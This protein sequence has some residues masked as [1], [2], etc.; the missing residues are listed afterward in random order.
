MVTSSEP[1][2]KVVV[3]RGNSTITTANVIT[4]DTVTITSGDETKTYT[5]ILYGDINKDGKISILDLLAEQKHL[6][7]TNKLTGTPS[8]AADVN[9]D[10]KISILD[11]LAVQKHLLGYSLI[12]QK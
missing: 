3:K 6:L 5:I 11:L 4:G 2:A 9:K 8:K 7:G 12:T 1:K 10:G